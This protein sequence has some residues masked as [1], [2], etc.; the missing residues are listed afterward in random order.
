[1]QKSRSGIVVAMALCW[2]A[3][4]WAQKNLSVEEFDKKL[5][6]TNQAQ[7]LDVRTASEYSEGHLKNSANV[8]IQN[9]QFEK[10][11]QKLDKDKPV[12]VY[13]LSGGR[14]SKAMSVLLKQGFKEVYNLD[15][16]YM[17]WSLA[18][19]PT[20]GAATDKSDEISADQFDKALKD[21]ALVLIDYN[22]KWCGPCKKLLPI[23]EK[24]KLTYASQLSVLM[25]DVDKNKGLIKQKGVDA[26]PALALY[27]NGQLVWQ[28][29]GLVDEAT[30][31]AQIEKRL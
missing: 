21:N 5:N 23:V 28:Q 13:C 16:G 31:K 14:S 4:T 26:L 6:A 27:K 17:K 29:T 2:S 18:D 24:L 7:V 8:D 1:M 15:G 22:A 12:F 3:T 10:D 30:L 25:I 9:A 11:I 20:A 19:K